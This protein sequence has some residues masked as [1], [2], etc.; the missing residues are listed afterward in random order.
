[1]LLCSVFFN[2]T[3]MKA[4]FPLSRTGLYANTVRKMRRGTKTP[5]ISYFRDSHTGASQSKSFGL[6]QFLDCPS[7]WSQLQLGLLS[8]EFLFI[9]YENLQLSQHVWVSTKNGDFNSFSKWKPKKIL[10][11]ATR[12]NSFDRKSPTWLQH[13]TACSYNWNN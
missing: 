13:T 10:K 5:N 6:S 4:T 11:L 7:V 3:D 1:M 9:C 12:Y 2:H 8:S